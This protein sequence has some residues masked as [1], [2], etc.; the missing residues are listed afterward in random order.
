VIVVRI[1]TGPIIGSPDSW[2]PVM[3]A[4]R[5]IVTFPMV[6]LIQNTRNRDATAIQ[7]S[8]DKLIRANRGAHAAHLDLEELDEGMPEAL[9]VRYEPLVQEAR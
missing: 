2:K 7:V 5:T 1:L 9:R 3:T 4:G 6:F 8:R